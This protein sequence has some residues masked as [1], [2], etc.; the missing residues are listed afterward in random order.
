MR[1]H[2][3]A[4]TCIEESDHCALYCKF[5]S[6]IT[7]VMWYLWVCMCVCVWVWVC[8]HV[9]SIFWPTCHIFTFFRLL[10]MIN[11][12]ALFFSQLLC[13]VSTSSFYSFFFLF[14]VFCVLCVCCARLKKI[15]TFVSYPLE[16]NANCSA[17]IMRSI[18]SEHDLCPVN[19]WVWVSERVWVSECT[20]RI[21]CRVYTSRLHLPQL[22]TFF[23][24]FELLRCL[25]PAPHNFYICI[26]KINT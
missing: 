1:L 8:A 24:G 18:P 15:F 23:A 3:G 13:L 2:T 12:L 5:D 25:S 26:K 14:F 20:L 21:D 4:M 9:S 16:P 6:I 17:R 19:L 22:F 11:T 10:M 7:R